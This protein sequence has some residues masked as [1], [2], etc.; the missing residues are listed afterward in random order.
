[1]GM[2]YKVH[3]ALGPGL[4]EHAYKEA[5]CVE[6]GLSGVPFEREKVF[7][8]EYRGQNVGTYFADIVVDDKIILE[9]KSVECF[10]PSMESQLINYL[11]ISGVPVGYLINFRNQ[12]VQWR[13]CLGRRA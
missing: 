10:H 3:N 2:V 13:R 1:M 5:L 8:L 4:L 7:P 12:Q 6:F 9:C 11:K